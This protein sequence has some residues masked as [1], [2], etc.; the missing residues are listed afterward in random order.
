[1]PGAADEKVR[2][3]RGRAVRHEDVPPS[4]EYEGRVRLLMFDDELDRAAYLRQLRGVEPG[5]RILGRV[6]GGEQ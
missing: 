1:V 6:P 3:A 2:H 5:L 4:V